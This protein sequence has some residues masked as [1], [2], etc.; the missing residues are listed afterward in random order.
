M[1][2][3][4]YSQTVAGGAD[5]AGV[6]FTGEAG[7]QEQGEWPALGRRGQVPRTGQ[8]PPDCCPVQSARNLQA[9]PPDDVGDSPALST[10]PPGPSTPRLRRPGSDSPG[11]ATCSAVRTPRLPPGLR[12]LRM[13]AGRSAQAHSGRGQTVLQL[14]SP[15]PIARL[16]SATCASCA[17]HQESLQK[18]TLSE[19]NL[20]RYFVDHRRVLL[21]GGNGGDGMSCFH[22][23]PR[24]EFGGPSGGDGG[25]G[26]NVILRADRQVKSLASVLSRYQ[27][28]HGEDGGS[29]NCFGRNGSPLYVQ[30]PLGTLVKEGEAT[31]AD[32]AQP[33]DEYIAALGGAGGKGNHFFLANDNR[34]P[35]TST[36]G[37]PGQERVL[38]LELKTM[39]H[40]GMVG[41]PNAGKSSL[42]RAISN[43]RPAVAAYPFTTLKPHVGIVHY[44]GHQQVTVADIPGIIRGAHLNRGLGFAFLRHIE[45]CQFLL[46]VLDLSAPEPWTQLEDLRFELEKYKGGL[47]ERPYAVI[48]NKVDLPEARAHL[49]ELQTR[50]GEAV[51]PLSATTGDNLEAL[52][53]RLKELF[54]KHALN[55]GC[56]PPMLA[57]RCTMRPGE[58]AQQ[59]LKQRMELASQEQGSLD[60]PSCWPAPDFVPLRGCTT[61]SLP[62]PAPAPTLSQPLSLPCLCLAPTSSRPLPLS[63]LCPALVLILAQ[64]WPPESVCLLEKLRQTLPCRSLP[65]AHTG[66]P[67]AAVSRD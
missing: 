32:L 19:K 18:K 26:G 38:F 54:D 66:A 14:G 28:V 42:L 39:A 17:K 62:C 64:P 46:F 23:E 11:D 57:S 50:L 21:R 60:L 16:L 7:Q 20:K 63:Q 9:D 51:I 58:A 59:Q 52:L 33:G 45:R 55:P 40:A 12:H 36:P 13:R 44:E 22:S 67:G 61:L 10:E 65:L 5:N 56:P 4:Q 1:W 30:V 41:F 48:G 34:A 15:K 2:D 37:Q 43:A 53:L 27:G 24:K 6:A 25:N 47:S 31:V 35:K 49:P 3:P 8:V 29:K